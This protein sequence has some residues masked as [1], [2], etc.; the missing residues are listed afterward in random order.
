MSRPHPDHGGEPL[1][2]VIVPGLHRI[3]GWNPQPA[4]EHSSWES[5]D[6]VPSRI[7]GISAFECGV[8]AKMFADFIF[9][10]P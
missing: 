4:S 2:V 5:R 6:P 3:L 9:L 10:L 8:L 1:G 7:V